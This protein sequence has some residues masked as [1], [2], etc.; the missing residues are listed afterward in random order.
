[1]NSFVKKAAFNKIR[2]NMFVIAI[3]IC[4]A[5]IC[6]AAQASATCAMYGNCGKKS[7]FGAELP[8]P[9][10]DTHF[11]PE[12]ATSDL[13]DLLVDL[14]GDEW[15]DETQL[16]CT[17]DQVLNL[18]K[19]LKKAHNIIASC[20]ACKKNFNNLFCHFTCAPDQATFVN[21]TK[22]QQSLSKKDTVAEVDVYMNSSWAS[23]F[24][25]SCKDVKFSATN[26]YAMDLIGGGAKNYSEFLKFLGDEKPLLGGSPFQI[27]YLYELDGEFTLF[28]DSVYACNDSKYKCACT[29]CELSCPKLEPLKEGSC[30]VGKLPCFSFTMLMF[31]ALLLIVIALWHVYYFKMKQKKS[32]ITSAE[33]ELIFNSSMT[34]EDQLFEV[35][36]TKSYWLNERVSKIIGTVSRLAIYR[37]YSVLMTTVLIVLASSVLLYKFGDL[38]KAPVNL[39]VSSNS[40]KF[41]EKEYYEKHFGPFYRIE[42]VFV[43]NDTGPALS[44]EAIEWWNKVEHDISDVL[45]S[46]EK[47]TYQDICFRPTQES[48]CVIES[49]IQYFPSGLP[50]EFSWREQLTACANTPVNCLPT[51]QQPL[52]K[53]VLFSDDDVLNS[54]AFVSTFLVSNHSESAILWERKLEEY[55]LDIEVPEGLR[56]SFNTEMSLEKELNRNGDVFIVSASYLVMFLYSS[57]ALK[58]RSGEGRWLLGFSGIVIVASSVLCSA[59]LLSALGVKSTLIIAE[60][61]PFLI[62]AIGVDNIFLITHEYDRI[63]E[64]DCSL[65]INEKIVAAVQHISPSVVLSF[66]CQ[67]GC[68][69]I[70]AF[71]SMPAVH[72]FAL[73]SAVAVFFNV[74]LQLTAYVAFLSLYEN[75][76]ASVSLEKDYEDHLFGKRYFNLISKKRKI[77]GLFISWTLIS[78]IFLPE[79][80][81]GLDQTLAVPK[82]SYLVD[83]FN[84]VYSYLNVGPPVFFVVKDLDLSKRENQQKICG[85]FTS[86]DDFSLANILENERERSTIV[87]PVANWFDDF[88]MFLSPQLDQCCRFKK[89]TTDICPPYFPARRCETCF[90]EG[91]WEYDMT[92]F[93]EGHELFEYLK[94]WIDTPSDPCPLGGKAPYSNAVAFNSTFVKA[95]TFRS[96]HR[97]L[98]SQDD[99][100]QAYEDAN[101]ISESLNNLDVFAY[102]P[103]YIFFVQYSTLVSLTLKLILVA[104]LLIFIAC[105][106]FIGSAQTASLL[107]LT[108]LMIMI[109]IGGFMAL[110][111]ISLNA[112]S[113]VNL[114]ICVGLAIEFCIHI[115]RAFTMVPSGTKNDRDSR[116]AYAMKTIGSSVF[117]GITLT[118]FIGVCVLAFA[119]SKIFDVFYFRMW[120][121]LVV[122]ASLHAMIFLPIILSLYGG[123]SYVD[124]SL[125]FLARE[126]QSTL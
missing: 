97:P 44:Y 99:Y 121:S 94:I 4:I 104:L 100:I 83:Y 71:V 111:G 14:C 57:W 19:N 85:K 6:S 109:D 50:D 13:I 31:Y 29:D 77:L 79:I 12:P 17:K 69:L 92:G 37:P 124:K 56:I 70:A 54:Q 60:V 39:W 74:M 80:K 58:R 53:N 96:A 81:L 125:D 113:L 33:D 87:D 67:C 120:F 72:N 34:S 118:K 59:G 35:Y 32:L 63:S 40:E 18:Q 1:M 116:T 23:V 86:C 73:Y 68:F 42:Q 78:L 30:K 9:V 11:K 107:I 115:A 26:G 8:C 90:Q 110:F 22:T 103:F 20:P 89:G 3:W 122:I 126:G 15:K 123:K 75:K 43:I 93:P 61:I 24:Y 88:M 119:Q 10:S 105:T 95:S 114:V 48:T 65:D 5:G 101:R 41:K 98:T 91:E 112:V 49:F 84:D 27:N 52:K 36:D 38:E 117:K 21:V 47:V 55:L 28:N 16:C 82:D 76:Y 64:L 108:V 25:D 62:L 51:F 45:E 7:V 102:S 106:I 46:V 66:I 2:D